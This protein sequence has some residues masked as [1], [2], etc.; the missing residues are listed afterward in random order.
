MFED[1]TPKNSKNQ[2]HGLWIDYWPTSDICSKGQYVNG[3]EYGYW[4][5]NWFGNK[6]EI[7]FK[8]K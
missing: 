2:N 3:K 7:I 1:I 6:P 8:L 4:L 5:E